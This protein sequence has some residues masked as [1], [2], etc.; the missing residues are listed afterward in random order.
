[1]LLLRQVQLDRSIPEE[2]VH[3]LCDPTFTERALS[4]LVENATRHNVS[5]GHV[6]VVLETEGSEF[7]L[8]V[9]DDGPG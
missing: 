3:A 9:L 5:G 1:M 7:V 6:A 8:R 2:R 4:N